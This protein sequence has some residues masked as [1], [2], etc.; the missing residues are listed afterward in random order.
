MKPHSIKTRWIELLWLIFLFFINETAKFEIWNKKSLKP[1]INCHF[2]GNLFTEKPRQTGT[3][4]C[5]SFELLFNLHK[6]FFRI[7][8]TINLS[9]YCL[10]R[11]LFVFQCQHCCLYVS[12]LFFNLSNAYYSPFVF[13]FLCLIYQHFCLSNCFQ[14]VC[15]PASLFVCFSASKRFIR[16][17]MELAE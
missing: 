3:I 2:N 14:P 4:I 17:V 11:F 13:S 8:S 1:K 16:F 12:L 9:A 15:A 7:K 6:I 5:N 10:A